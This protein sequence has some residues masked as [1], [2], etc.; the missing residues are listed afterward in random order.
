MTFKS[1]T[2]HNQR[3][4]K[5]LRL[6]AA[7]FR[8]HLCDAYEHDSVF[9]QTLILRIQLFFVRKKAETIVRQSQ[10]NHRLNRAWTFLGKIQLET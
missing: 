9:R 1:Y 3:I 10:I 7:K 8:R 5:Q 2:D 6:I 4:F